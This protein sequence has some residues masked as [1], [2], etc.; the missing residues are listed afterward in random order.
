MKRL[1][2]LDT[3]VLITFSFLCLIVNQR[4]DIEKEFRIEPTENG[5]RTME[6]L[7]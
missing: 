5:E 6:G 3:N 7:R 4:A 1:I 2:K